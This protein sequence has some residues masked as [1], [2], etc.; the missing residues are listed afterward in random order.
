M[1]ATTGV[2]RASVCGTVFPRG[3]TLS[4]CLVVVGAAAVAV[5]AALVGGARW[6]DGEDAATRLRPWF[7]RSFRGFCGKS[8]NDDCVFTVMVEN[9]SITV[10]YRGDGLQNGGPCDQLHDSHHS[11]RVCVR[12]SSSRFNSTVLLPLHHSV[13]HSIY[14][15]IYL[16]ACA[17]FTEPTGASPSPSPPSSS[18]FRVS[19]S[20]PVAVVDAFRSLSGAC[21]AT[22]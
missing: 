11:F 12:A 6:Q 1:D 7:F 15:S 3:S 22:G 4:L 8:S 2:V 13:Y 10:G 9:I 18:L 21:P 5:A 14:L 17:G 16:F 20:V 19:V